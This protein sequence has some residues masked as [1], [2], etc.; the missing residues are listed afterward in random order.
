MIRLEYQTDFH[1]RMARRHGITDRTY[2]MDFGSKTAMK[3]WLRSNPPRVIVGVT[4]FQGHQPPEI[5]PYCVT[6][7][8]NKC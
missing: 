6:V 7:I 3:A 5:D 8:R 4:V 1:L 2:I